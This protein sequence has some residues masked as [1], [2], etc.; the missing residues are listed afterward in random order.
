VTE[1][2]VYDSDEELTQSAGG[3]LADAIA[4]GGAAVIAATPATAIMPTARA[5]SSV[6]APS[7]A[8]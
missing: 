4:E 5:V 6:P 2:C 1:P 7:A 8:M 3:Y